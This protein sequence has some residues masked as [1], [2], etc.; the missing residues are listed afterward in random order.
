MIF[1]GG[2]F[3]A[4]RSLSADA[5]PYSVAFTRFF[6]VSIFMYFIL[7]KSEGSIPKLT[8]K[9]LMAVTLMGVSGIFA[10]NLFFFYGLRHITA[11]RASLII[12]TN[13][14]FTAIFSALFFKDE[15]LNGLRSAGIFISV[16]GALVVITEGNLSEILIHNIGIGD[17]LIAGCA[18]SWTAYSLI[19][20]RV[21]KGLSPLAAVYYSACAGSVFLFFPAAFSGELFKISNFMWMDW[22][23]IV[24][25]AYFAATLGFFWYN[26]GI[27]FIGAAKTSVFAGFIPVSA[28][29]LGWALLDEL[30]SVSLIVGAAL[31]V[32]GV[33]LTNFGKRFPFKI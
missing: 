16:V 33:Y 31:I 20:K 4:G 14:V 5:H 26:E 13:P 6:L 29:I 12:A 15:R 21:M 30:I 11:G 2:A 27:H 7:K 18:L 19:G 1:W 3:V 24:Y 9:Q 22:F 32:C 23:N 10:Y 25:M 8:M 17:L 28:I